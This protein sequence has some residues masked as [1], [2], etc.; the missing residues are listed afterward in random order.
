[1]LGEQRLGLGAAQ[2]GLEGGGHRLLVD[3]QQPLHPDQV[4]THHAGVRRTR[5]DE[6]TGDRRPATEGHDREPVG[7]GDGEERLDLGP[8]DRAHD[9]VGGIGQVAGA[10]LQQVGG[11]LASRAQRAGRVVDQDV[12][13]T[14]DGLERGERGR[15]DDGSRRGRTGDGRLLVDPEGELDQPSG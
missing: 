10:R 12:R 15:A 2:A 1:M 7:V 14:D 4:E 6:T 13:G 5:R 8:V 11:R 9:H 3:R